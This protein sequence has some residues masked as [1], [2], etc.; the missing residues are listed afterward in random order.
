M[1]TFGLSESHHMNQLPAHL[2][3]GNFLLAETDPNLIF[4]PE[5][6]SSEQRLMAETAAK[7]MEKEVLPNQ[8]ALEH[9]VEGLAPKIFRQAGALGLL[10][11]GVPEDYK[12][13]GLGR[14]AI[15]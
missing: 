5:E 13:L 4:T 10:G 15:V 8:E 14:A 12:G 1:V 6:L 2:I 9:Q 11:M 3:G 7:F